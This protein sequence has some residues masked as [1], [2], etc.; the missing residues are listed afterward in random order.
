[1]VLMDT[2]PTLISLI[3]FVFTSVRKRVASLDGWARF[4]KALV[5]TRRRNTQSTALAEPGAPLEN[6][7]LNQ[8]RLRRAA[9]S[10][11]LLLLL[12]NPRGRRNPTIPLASP[13]GLE[14]DGRSRPQQPRGPRKRGARPQ[15]HELDITVAS[16][17]QGSGA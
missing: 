8:R 15:P 3:P 16:K 1:M 5:I 10:G 2:N 13:A 12:L 9:R 7:L 11:V 17:H 6:C 4:A 14:K